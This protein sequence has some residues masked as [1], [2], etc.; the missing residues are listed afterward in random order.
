LINLVEIY[1]SKYYYIIKQD[2]YD[3][4]KERTSEQSISHKEM[5]SWEDHCEFVESRPYKHWYMV[6]SENGIVGAIYLTHQ[7]EI[8]VSIFNQFKGQGH[9]ERAVKLLMATN[10]GPFLANVNPKNKVSRNL[11]EKLGGKI[12]QVTYEIQ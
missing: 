7:N 11:F 12:I 2:L 5:P 4:L 6:E 3:L 9:A 8:G 10:K 1:N